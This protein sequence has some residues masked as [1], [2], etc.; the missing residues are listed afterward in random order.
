[1]GKSTDDDTIKNRVLEL[2]DKDFKVPIKRL[3]VIANT[4]ETDKSGRTFQQW[5]KK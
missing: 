1:M 3:E 2:S 5:Q 4:L